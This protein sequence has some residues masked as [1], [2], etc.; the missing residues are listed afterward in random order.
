MMKTYFSPMSFNFLNYC[1]PLKPIWLNLTCV[2]TLSGVTYYISDLSS[3]IVIRTIDL[4]SV[5]FS[6]PVSPFHY[7]VKIL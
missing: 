6:T 7:N 2:F 4:V 5:I 3:F 1:K